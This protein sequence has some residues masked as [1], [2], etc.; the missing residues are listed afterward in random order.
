MVQ[1]QTALGWWLKM[2]LKPA[3]QAPAAGRQLSHQQK[4][5][6]C[7]SSRLR[8]RPAKNIP[9][10]RAFPEASQMPLSSEPAP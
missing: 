4:S 9:P 7:S 3:A 6:T 5:V 10:P 1:A 8:L 2:M